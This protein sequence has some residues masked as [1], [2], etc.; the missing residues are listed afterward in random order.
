MNLPSCPSYPSVQSTVRMQNACDTCNGLFQK[1]KDLLQK[2]VLERAGESIVRQRL[3][4]STHA[5]NINV[6]IVVVERG[7]K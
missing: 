5:L 3:A 1:R 4:A 2:L 7:R 6:G